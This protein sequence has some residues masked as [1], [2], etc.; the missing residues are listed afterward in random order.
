MKIYQIYDEVNEKAGLLQTDAPDTI[1][2]NQLYIESA[3]DMWNE[4]TESTQFN[5]EWEFFIYKL[6][7]LGYNANRIFIEN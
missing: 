5:D 2:F 7:T 1:D 4:T 3:E 6:Q